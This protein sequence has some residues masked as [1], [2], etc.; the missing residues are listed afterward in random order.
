MR[1]RTSAT[2]AVA[3]ATAALGLATAAP[4]VADE[5]ASARG[6]CGFYTSGMFAYYNHCAQSGKV[7]IHVDKL[8]P[9]PDEDPCVGPGI[10]SI[11]GSFF[12]T[13]A[14]YTGRC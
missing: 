9:F 5:G 2:L 14:Y 6:T 3:A 13:G 11:G 1:R 4:A 8:F 10:T 12:T 7:R